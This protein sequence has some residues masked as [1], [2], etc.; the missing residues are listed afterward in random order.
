MGLIGPSRGSGD[1]GGRPT[2]CGG[3]LGPSSVGELLVG[4]LFRFMGVGLKL[5][6]FSMACGAFFTRLT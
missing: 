5:C 2:L 4:P 1:P 3:L 6:G